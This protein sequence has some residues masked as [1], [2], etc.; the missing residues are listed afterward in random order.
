MSAGSCDGGGK[1]S[2]SMSAVGVPVCSCCWT[3]SCVTVSLTTTL[4]TYALRIGSDAPAQAGL[5]V[6]VMLF[7]G[8]YDS[9]TYGPSEIVCCPSSA[10]P[11]T[12]ALYAF[13]AGEKA[14]RVSM[15][16][17]KLAGCT[18]LNSTV[19]LSLATTPGRSVL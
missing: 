5:R 11:G 9:T 15:S 16:A 13:G 1:T 4:S 10:L 12:Y 8:A 2:H 3:E 14:V 7:V 6:K 17:K 18:S 19:R